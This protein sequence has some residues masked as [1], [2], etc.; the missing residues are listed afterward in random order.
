MIDITPIINAVIAVI[1]AVITLVVI[2]KI[3][4]LL[5][6]KIGAEQTESL[7]RWVDIF[8]GA[9]EQLY[10]DPAV[11][12]EYVKTKLESIGYTYTP[13]VDSAIESAVLQLHAALRD[14]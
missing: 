14:Y 1:A 4:V 11:K 10:A 9:A 13:E 2:P 12:K 8:V 7:C 6:Q 3:R 5:I